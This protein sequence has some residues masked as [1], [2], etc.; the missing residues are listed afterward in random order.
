MLKVWNISEPYILNQ[1]GGSGESRFFRSIDDAMRDDEKKEEEVI[2]RNPRFSGPPQEVTRNR[3]ILQT[4]IDEER[5]ARTP[6]P[7]LALAKEQKRVAK[8]DALNKRENERRIEHAKTLSA[9]SG[10]NMDAR[11]FTTQQSVP[12]EDK[13][14]GFREE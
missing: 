9:L 3:G 12:K 13:R 14:A 10:I 6:S 11:L 5:A 7:Q 2:P 1:R 8:E 4:L